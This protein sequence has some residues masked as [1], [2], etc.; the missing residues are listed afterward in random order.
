MLHTGDTVT[1]SSR[2]GRLSAEVEVTDAIR[3]G[4]VSLPHGATA[5]DVNLL[6]SSDD[7]DPL[8]GMPVLSGFAVLVEPLAGQVATQ[9]S[10]GPGP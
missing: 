8:T 3:S 6:T 10:A 2:Q 5:P 4:V 7:T 9:A 1:V